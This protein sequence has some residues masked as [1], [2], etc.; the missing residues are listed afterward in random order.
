MKGV[1]FSGLGAIC[2]GLAKVDACIM[3]VQSNRYR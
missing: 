3:M 2:G 1:E